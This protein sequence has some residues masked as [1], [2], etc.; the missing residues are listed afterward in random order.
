MAAKDNFFVKNKSIIT[1]LI[2]EVVALTAF[3]FGNISYIFGLAG[4]LLAIVGFFFAYEVCKDKKE[5]LWLLLPVGI[6]FLISGIGAFG[7]H[8]KN[9]YP[10]ANVSLFLALPAFLACG[11]FLRKLDDVKPKTMLMVVGAGLAAITLFGLLSTLFEYGLFYSLIYKSTPNYYYNGA[12]YDVTKEMYWLTGFE[13]SEVFV[14]YGSIF[15]LLCASFLPGL[16]FISPKKERND[17]IIFALIG[18][19][20]LL[21]ML[22][23]P[24]F[25]AII[26]VALASSFAFILK[27]LKE[28]TLIKKVIG[29]SLLGVVGLGILFFIIALANAAGGFKFNGFLDRLFV[30]NKIMINCKPVFEAL[31][32]KIDGV[33]VN[34]FGLDL[35][36]PYA[37]TANTENVLKTETNIFEVELLKEVGLIGAFLFIGFVIMMGYFVYKYIKK[38]EDSDAVKSIIVVL[39]LSYFAFVSFSN[40]VIIAPHN[41]YSYN[42]FLRSSALLVVLFLLGYTFIPP[43][44]KEEKE[45]E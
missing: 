29:F 45:D 42:P 33:M 37:G 44:K 8:S 18:G 40:S 7:A 4:A 21:T 3:N 36:Y 6:L 31:F 20:G 32:A 38:S 34:F 5:F 12:P 9:F 10:I 27:Y 28:H 39:L 41:E 2:L 13:F 14:E 24:N 19:I 15:T 17:F 26:V 23:I 1:F 30:S 25:K 11:F 22:I 16:L 35:T 43:V